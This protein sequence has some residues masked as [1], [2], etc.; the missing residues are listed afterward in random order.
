MKNLFVVLLL[1]VSASIAWGDSS[2]DA[3]QQ[4]LNEH[5]AKRADIAAR[6][7]AQD[8]KADDIKFVFDAYK[9]ADAQYTQDLAAHNAKV[10]ELKRGYE[11]L[12]PAAE[13]YSQRVDAHNA[14]Q[15]V[16]KCTNNSCDGSCA[17]YEAERSQLD[18]NKAS[19]QAAYAPLDAQGNQLNTEKSYLDQTA[20]KLDTIQS[21]L[22]PDIAAWKA[23]EAALKA[24]WDANEADIV[25]LQAML[26]KLKGENDVCFSKIP[27]ACQM[28]PLLDDKC[29]QLHAACG[30]LF[31]GN[32]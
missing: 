7:D 5:I 25:Q 28:N 16:E 21:Q 10:T 1:L 23:A 26:A 13:N 9:K 14:H 15:C 2:I 29:E 19:L 6:S 4:Q 32:R 8:K 31:D 3:I 17:W 27:P 24:E 30:K 11:L 12:A 20:Q 22:Q 18:A